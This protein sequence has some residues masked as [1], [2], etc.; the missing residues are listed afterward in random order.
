MTMHPTSEL[1]RGSNRWRPLIWGGAA[2]LLLVPAVAMQFTTEVNWTPGDF[3]AMGVIL[4][5]ACGIY[6]LSAWLSGNTVYRA[7]FGIAVLAGFL[8]VW[9][10]LAVGMIGSED[11][12]LNLMFGGVL[13]LAMLGSLA[14]RFRAARM[15]VVMAA[16]AAA[17]L[18]AAG[19]GLVV[20]LTVGTDEVAGPNLSREVFLTACFAVPW[21]ASSILF[22][23]A[24]SDN[25]AA[26]SP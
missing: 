22:R 11:D 3:I 8:T 21:L 10:N 18:V 13:V 14:A 2:C 26:E 23:Q 5:I 16:T 9:V 7:A 1:R 25:T 20:G 17:Q 6:E 19:I 12:N 15:A 4:A 24:A